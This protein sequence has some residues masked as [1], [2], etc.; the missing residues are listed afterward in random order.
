MTVPSITLSLRGSDAGVGTSALAQELTALLAFQG[1]SVTLT[2]AEHPV[3]NAG[4]AQDILQQMRDK[5]LRLVVDDSP[6]YPLGQ[7]I[8]YT[9]W[10]PLNADPKS[11]DEAREVVASTA[12]CLDV[13]Q[14]ALHARAVTMNEGRI[15][16]KLEEQVFDIWSKS[17]W[18]GMASGTD[19]QEARAQVGR[20]WPDRPPGDFLLTPFYGLRTSQATFRAITGRDPVE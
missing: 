14:E 13:S 17:R 20:A 7:R 19:V 4:V 3:R 1:F 11:L 5:G 15:V 12:G 10:F 16:L 9:H 6:Q 18:I 8:V 2:M